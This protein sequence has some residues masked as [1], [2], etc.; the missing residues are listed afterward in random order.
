MD[1]GALG[2]LD[3]NKKNISGKQTMVKYSQNMEKYDDNILWQN[4]DLITK[5]QF[6]QPLKETF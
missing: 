3:L 1:T 6:D 4:D 5:E 2:S